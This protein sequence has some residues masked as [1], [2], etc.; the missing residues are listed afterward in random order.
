MF[1]N[2]K[3]ALLDV[4]SS[5]AKSPHWGGRLSKADV[6]KASTEFCIF[7]V[8]IGIIAR[9]LLKRFV[10]A[11][12]ADSRASLWW[13][14]LLPMAQAVLR[15]GFARKSIPFLC[16]CWGVWISSRTWQIRM[17]K[18][19]SSHESLLLMLRL[20]NCVTA[21]IEE[22]TERHKEN[23]KMSRISS[24]ALIPQPKDSDFKDS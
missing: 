16:V 19:D 11:A 12:H 24:F 17:A 18:L 9:N 10:K 3:V 14:L 8:I 5:I 23:T 7:L 2:L 21:A 20:M 13:T 4:E 15:P 22:S 6:S 1:H